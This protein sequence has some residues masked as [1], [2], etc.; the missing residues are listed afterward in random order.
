MGSCMRNHLEFVKEMPHEK[1]IVSV[2][3]DLMV[4]VLKS[5]EMPLGTPISLERY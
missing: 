1:I 2:D 4:R 5:S 3:A